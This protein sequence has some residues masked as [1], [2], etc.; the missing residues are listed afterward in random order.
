MTP[1][2]CNILLSVFFG[3]IGT[4]NK[5]QLFSDLKIKNRSNSHVC[6]GINKTCEMKWLLTV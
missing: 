2:I 5:L 3:V 6:H 1:N 4:A